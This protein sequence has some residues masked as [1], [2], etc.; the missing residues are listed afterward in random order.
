MLRNAVRQIAVLLGINTVKPRANYSNGSNSRS[1]ICGGICSYGGFGSIHSFALCCACIT[2]H[3]LH[4]AFVGGT[5]HPQSHARNHYPARSRQPFAKLVRIALPL[6]RRV[7][8]AHHCN[9]RLLLCQPTLN[10]PHGIQQH[11]RVGHI[12]QGLRVIRA[13]QHQQAALHASSRLLQP[14]P[15]GFYQCLCFRATCLQ[16]SRLPR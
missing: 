15:S 14:L 4:C 3:S 6:W 1:Y 2:S 8:A 13:A 5:V 16:S 9:A 11:G 7:A 10:L 12:E